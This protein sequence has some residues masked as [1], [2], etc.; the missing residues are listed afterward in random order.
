MVSMSNLNTHLLLQKIAILLTKS[1]TG[2][3]LT[4]NIFNT[5]VVFLLASQAIR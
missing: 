2:G 1:V 5:L 3:H 4:Q